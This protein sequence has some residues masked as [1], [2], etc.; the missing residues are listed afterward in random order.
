MNTFYFDRTKTMCKFWAYVCLWQNNKRTVI[1]QGLINNWCLTPSQPRKI[2]IYRRLIAQSTVQGHLRALRVIPGW[3]HCYQ[4]IKSTN[5]SLLNKKKVQSNE[6]THMHGGSCIWLD[7]LKHRNRPEPH[8]TSHQTTWQFI[9]ATRLQPP[10]Q[11]TESVSLFTCNC[12][13]YLLVYLCICV[14]F[15]FFLIMK[16]WNKSKHTRG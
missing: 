8:D 12:I 14:G 2:F 10:P 15:F 5:Q 16:V 7:T 1:D 4:N 11:Y 6:W 9:S 3:L 13:V